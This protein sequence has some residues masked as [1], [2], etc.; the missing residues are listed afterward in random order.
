MDRRKYLKS[1]AGGTPLFFLPED[2]IFN[3]DINSSDWLI[4][5]KI[6]WENNEIY[7][8][9]VFESMPTKDF[10]FQPN[11]EMMS[12]GKLFSHIGYSLNIY[13]GVINGNNVLPEPQ[14]QDRADILEYLN[15]GFRLFFT[16]I[17]NINIE[18][19][20][21]NKHHYPDKEP[22]KDF[23]ISDIIILAYNHTVHHTAQATVYLRLKNII[24]PKYRF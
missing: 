8:H 16:A 24:P 3:K 15:N 14:A 6:R 12:F 11:P 1:I 18:D 23:S 2:P 19:I 10:E 22:W 17:S 5:F 21:T 7:C 13:A 9:E 4:P 20:H